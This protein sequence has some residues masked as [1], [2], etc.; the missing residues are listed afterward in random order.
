MEDQA[1]W[2]CRPAGHADGH[3]RAD[4]KSGI[5]ILRKADPIKRWYYPGEGDDFLQELL[6]GTFHETI[7]L[8]FAIELKICPKAP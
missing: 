7:K 2:L 1:E 5:S 4:E 8:Q 6:A 3:M